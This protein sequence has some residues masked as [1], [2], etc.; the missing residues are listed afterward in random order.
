M[1]KVL[2]WFGIA[3]VMMFMLLL[4]WSLLRAGAMAD[5]RMEAIIYKEFYESKE[6]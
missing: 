2:I 5:K 4:I 3:A 1:V 6:G